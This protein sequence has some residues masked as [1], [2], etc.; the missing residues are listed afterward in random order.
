MNREFKVAVRQ[1]SQ[2]QRFFFHKKI[3]FTNKI[4]LPLPGEQTDISSWEPWEVAIEARKSSTC[5]RDSELWR[6]S[7]GQM[8]GTME[9]NSKP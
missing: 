4:V 5:L 1:E 8:E 7:S 2:K 9:Y 3:V 6:V